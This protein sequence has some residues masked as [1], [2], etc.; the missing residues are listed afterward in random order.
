ML[1]HAVYGGLAG[2][3]SRRRN[4]VLA[5]AGS[6]MLIDVDHLAYYLGWP[7]PPRTSHSLCFL[8]LAPIIMSLAA[9]SGI[10]GA[11][12]SPRLAASMGLATVMAHLAWDAL[13][14]G[15]AQ[16][17][18]WLP[19]SATPVALSSAIGILLEIGAVAVMAFGSFGPHRSR[20]R[21]A[22]ERTDPVRRDAPRS[23][24]SY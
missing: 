13:T 19:V 9:R 10:L 3:P 14:G 5:M 24:E 21:R 16:V 6:A 7:V 18:F 22:P 8:V 12:G 17:P 11:D 20:T 15:E 2:L 1:L 23:S 4:V